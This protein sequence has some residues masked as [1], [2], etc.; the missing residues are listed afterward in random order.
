MVAG[1]YWPDIFDYPEGT[2][3]GRI[4]QLF[5]VTGRGKSYGRPDQGTKRRA[6]A[7]AHIG[8]GVMLPGLPEAP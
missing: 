2:V 7:P 3:P 5:V 4:G 1:D 6:P 8:I